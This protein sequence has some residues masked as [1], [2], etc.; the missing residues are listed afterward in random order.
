[1]LFRAVRW[2]AF[3]PVAFVASVLAG[4]ALSYLGSLMG[5]S[6]WYIWLV[7]GA[8]SAA[9]FFATAF[10]IAPQST[11]AV[12]WSSVVVVGTLG[13][14]SAVGALVAGR[15]PTSSLAGLTMVGFAVYVARQPFDALTKQDDSHG[16][17]E[18]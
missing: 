5:G 16:A 4:A 11:E 18:S 15:E 10:A 7:S 17:I 6:T 3:I 8:A 9:A 14:L 13:A 2:F 1:M 12:K